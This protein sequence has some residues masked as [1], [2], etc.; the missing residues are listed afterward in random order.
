MSRDPQIPTGAAGFAWRLAAFYAALFAMLGVQLPFLPVWLDARGL[1]AWEIGILLAIPMVVRVVAIPVATRA[2]DRYGALRGAIVFAAVA[3]VAGYGLVGVAGGVAGIMLAYALASAFYTPLMPLADAY[4]LRGLAQHGR[5]YGPVRLWGSAAFIAGSF[6]AG[7]LL[8]RMAPGN[9][10]WLLVA[11]MVPAA[12][13]AAALAPLGLLGTERGAR[14]ENSERSAK[15]PSAGSLL[16]SKAFLAVALAASFVQASHAV[17]YGFST[18]DWQAAGLDGAAIGAL[19][20]LG[21]LAEIALFAVS[22]RLRVG[23]VALLLIGAAGA[24]VRWGAMALDPPLALLP[25]L[26]C[27]HGLSF[28]A[29]HLGAVGFMARAAPV[30]IGA[31]AQGYL[32]VAQGLVMAAAMGLAGVL[33]ARYGGL[34]YASMAAM[35]AAGGMCAFAAYRIGRLRTSG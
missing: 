31:T 11:A 35:A 27:L 19:W 21:V 23:P 12:V 26:Q 32:S 2:A 14:S 25:L 13:A 28:G 16:R 22:G 3:T 15:T 9:L 8:D 33:Y 17:Y 29:T 10:I 1:N 34:A 6:G 18:L 30:E 4:A 7:L 24:A 5:S 20:S